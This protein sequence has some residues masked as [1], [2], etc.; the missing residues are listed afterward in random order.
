[1]RIHG[2]QGL[3]G[4]GGNVLTLWDLAKGTV[5]RTWGGHKAP[6][7]AVRVDRMGRLY[8][9]DQDGFV[10]VWEQGQIVRSIAAHTEPILAMTL[11]ANETQLFTASGDRTVKV[12]EVTTGKRL[13]VLAGH[14]G[15]VTSIVLGKDG[16]RAYTGSADRS[17]KVWDLEAGKPLATWTG[18]SEGVNAVALAADES[19]L[20]SGGD[21]STIRVWP[22]KNDQID[23]ARDAILLEQH[24]KAVTCLAFSRDGAT[25]VSG[26]Q[27]KT[28]KVWNWS[29][30]RVTRTISGHK[31][32]ITS[33]V[34][35]DANTLL[36]TSDDLS[37]CRWDLASGEETGQLDFGAIGDCPRCLAMVGPNRFVVGTSNWMLLEWEMGRKK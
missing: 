15:S 10:H 32:W 29:Q 33:F 4:G 13:Q 27:D 17:I 14:S 21:D 36:T 1:M 11:N 35:A 37:I 20:A 5:E 6:V 25:L 30:G 16:K 22:I 23:P 26:S 31:N 12:W 2:S 3:V 8:S 28:L 34:F 9:A 18:H 19:W 7:T 24:K